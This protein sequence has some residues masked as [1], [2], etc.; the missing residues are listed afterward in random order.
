MLRRTIVAALAALALP[1]AAHAA[2]VPDGPELVTRARALADASAAEWAA[3]VRERG[4]IVDPLGSPVTGGYGRAMLA[5]GMLRT[6]LRRDDAA[7][8][9][10]AEV[11]L[12]RA[13][14]SR[15]PFSQLAVA[16]ALVAAGAL[17][18]E[19]DR[20]TRRDLAGYDVPVVGERAAACSRRDDCWSNLKLVDALAVLRSLD[21]GFAGATPSARLADGPAARRAALDVLGRRAAAVMAPSAKLD[22]PGAPRLTGGVLSDPPGNA[23]AYHALSTFM[24]ARGIATLPAHE[25]TQQQV[26]S[27][28]RT[29]VA[30]HGLVAPDGDVSYMG[31]GQQQAWTYAL[32]AGA[33]AGALRLLGPREFA[34]GRCMGVIHRALGIL[35]RRQASGAD[36][37]VGILPRPTWLR[38]VDRY[39]NRIDYEGLVLFGLHATADALEETASLPAPLPPAGGEAGMAF[40]DPRATGLAV[41]QAGGVWMAVHRAAGHPTDARYDAGLL[42]VQV[43]RHGVWRPAL[44]PRPK[45]N[46]PE[47]LPASGPLLRTPGGPAR[48]TGR[49]IEVVR[50][51]EVLVE[52]AW[53]LRGRTVRSGTLRFRA[54]RTGVR[55]ALDAHQ[56]ERFDVREVVAPGA[57]E[58]LV[59]DGGVGTATGSPVRRTRPW[60]TAAR[61]DSDELRW[62]VRVR[63]DGMLRLRWRLR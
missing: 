39:V 38:G 56:G 45:T 61:D 5:Y 36:V 59:L 3:L 40:V 48:F 22:V 16:E 62:G 54:T 55:L 50:P 23:I 57:P 15:D 60:G 34:A 11:A 13:A 47:R 4:A 8:R 35:E 10:L 41:T 24:L 17:R 21:A 28:R 42:A 37:G 2:P 25:R 26:V 49:R 44:D 14:Y 20:S 9:E 18:E 30:L 46:P 19:L 33:C 31:R 58:A 29:V 27:L 63:A 32:T 52:G 6:A 51:G 12:A 7:L 53:R 1:A 43:R